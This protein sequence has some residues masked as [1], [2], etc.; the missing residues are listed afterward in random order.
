MNAFIHPCTSHSI[1]TMISGMASVRFIVGTAPG[2]PKLKGRFVEGDPFSP[3]N[4]SEP[5]G[6]THVLR[7]GVDIGEAIKMGALWWRVS[8]DEADLASGQSRNVSPGRVW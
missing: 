1:G 5:T 8:G 7:H 4:D 2:I 6:T 3:H